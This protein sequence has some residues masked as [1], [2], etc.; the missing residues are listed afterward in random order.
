MQHAF[1]V[2]RR[3]RRPDPKGDPGRD[4]PLVGKERRLFEAI[5]R[6]E[7]AHGDALAVT[8]DAPRQRKANKALL[9]KLEAAL[10][11]L[12]SSTVNLAMIDLVLDGSYEQMDNGRDL[13]GLL[14]KAVAGLKANEGLILRSTDRSSRQPVKDDEGREIRVKTSGLKALTGVLFDY[15]RTE[16]DLPWSDQWEQNA[17][18]TDNGMKLAKNLREKQKAARK[19]APARPGKKASAL[20]LMLVYEVARL[21]D[22]RYTLDQCS[23]AMRPR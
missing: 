2:A 20:S 21:I 18:V 8:G 17:S 15:V 11:A 19:A 1:E 13:P 12:E 5:K 10:L 6:A 9:K 7:Q 23:V 14:R 16:T 3:V 22:H 4:T